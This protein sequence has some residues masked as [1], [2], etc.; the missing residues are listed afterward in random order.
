MFIS[1]YD[2]LEAL[3][4]FQRNKTQDICFDKMKASK[5]NFI[6]NLIP[7]SGSYDIN[8]NSVNY[9]DSLQFKESLT[10]SGSSSGDD[11][12]LEKSK[13]NFKS[14]QSILKLFTDSKKSQQHDSAFYATKNN[15]RKSFSQ[16]KWTVL[17]VPLLYLTYFCA[18]Y[19]FVSEHS[20][21]QVD[22][23]EPLMN[24][25]VFS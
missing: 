7:R 24:I 12:S 3:N 19:T 1:I 16:S 8:N 25:F 6:K 18:V 21:Y 11:Q 20:T 14:T 13:K 5:S 22:T 15:N 10:S 2:I 17:G 9:D 23:I 4:R